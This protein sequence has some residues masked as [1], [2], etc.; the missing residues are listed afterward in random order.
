MNNQY[1][2]AGLRRT[3]YKVQV[4]HYRYYGNKLL[5][6]YEVQYGSQPNSKGGMTTIKITTPENWELNGFAECSEKDAYNRKLGVKIALNRAMMKE[7]I[8]HDNLD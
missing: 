6:K 4:N 1:T 8:H 7:F 2:V 3:G 5:Q